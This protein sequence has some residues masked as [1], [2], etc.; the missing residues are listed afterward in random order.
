MKLE[1]IT[2]VVCG[3][4]IIAGCSAEKTMADPTI[5]IEVDT[6]LLQD[7][8]VVIESVIK[9]TGPSTVTFLSWGT[10]FESNV[11]SP[12]LVIQTDLSG[13]LETVPYAGIM[14]KRLPPQQ[15][16]YIETLSGQI[17]SNTLDITESYSFCKDRDYIMTYTGPLYKPDNSEISVTRATEK[18]STGDSF[19]SC[20]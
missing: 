16:D 2:I 17:T 7:G 13:E 4:F 12:F 10:P 20:N 19:P 3:L 15:T 11:S 5:S 6:Q 14:I 18:F 1:K 9:N 8:R